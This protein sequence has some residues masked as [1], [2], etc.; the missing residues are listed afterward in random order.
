M[1]Q[2]P[3][4]GASGHEGSGDEGSW[5]GIRHAATSTQ[6]GPPDRRALLHGM[7]T[8]T[9]GLSALLLPR[10]AAAASSPALEAAATDV[11]VTY[12][13]GDIALLRW[14]Q[15]A[16][17][18]VVSPSSPQ[19]ATVHADA[20]GS[21]L[22]GTLTPG[23]ADRFI[24][25][26]SSQWNE[27]NS[28]DPSIAWS[29]GSNTRWWWKNSSTTVDPMT[30]PY[31]AYSMITGDRAVTLR[32]LCIHGLLQGVSGGP[33]DVSVRTSI[34]GYAVPLRHVTGLG[35]SSRNIV[36]NLSGLSTIPAGMGVTFRLYLF[37]TTGF[38][39]YPQF[40]QAA[41]ATGLTDDDTY[42]SRQGTA[43][44][45]LIGTLET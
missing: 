32:S 23:P 31:V 12:A 6:G 42:D 21:G 13:S 3:P 33:F 15:V 45:S 27:V 10:A 28:T 29:T 44:V 39:G 7:A 34:G 4:H 17:Q 43:S 9:L 35:S 30:A 37:N 16:T 40:S 5:N 18:D 24:S 14:P 1:P 36:V 11:P 26:T 25:S 38:A 20:T 2:R 8:G 19:A 41:A 22:S